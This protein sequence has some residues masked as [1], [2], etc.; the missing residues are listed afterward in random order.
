MRSAFEGVPGAG[1]QRRL[2]LELGFPLIAG[3]APSRTIVLPLAREALGGKDIIPRIRLG[4]MCGGRVNERWRPVRLIRLNL[5]PAEAVLVPG[6]LQNGRMGSQ[7]SG[8]RGL[9]DGGATV[10]APSWLR[11][12]TR[13]IPCSAQRQLLGWEKPER[14]CS[15][16]FLWRR[17]GLYKGNG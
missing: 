7:F 5:L 11:K 16:G 17:R 15:P 10:F 9:F 8:G 14:T 3:T 13:I 6:A 1:L 4:T 12:K 2:R